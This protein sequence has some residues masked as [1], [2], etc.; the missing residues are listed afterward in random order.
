MQYVKTSHQNA[1]T[2]ICPQQNPTRQSSRA[3]ANE[4]LYGDPILILGQNHHT[5]P[6]PKIPTSKKGRYQN[7]I[8]M[9]VQLG[10]SKVY[11][12]RQNFNPSIP[13]AR[14]SNPSQLP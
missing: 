10:P 6:Y 9:E 14:I 5:L 2:H 3:Y 7:W 13:G 1:R 4:Q 8:S 12:R 11:F